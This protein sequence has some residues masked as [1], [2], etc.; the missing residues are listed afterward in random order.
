VGR[1]DF[2]RRKEACRNFVA[3][4][5]QSAGDLGESEAEMM[6]DILEKD[7]GRLDLADDAR[8]MRPEVARVLGAEALARDGK[9]LARVARYAVRRITG[10]MRSV[11]LCRVEPLCLVMVVFRQLDS[12][13]LADFRSA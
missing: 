5:D 4:A 11:R 1:T 3:H 7:E 6:G 8:D 10:F 9:R 12:C 13:G 2:R